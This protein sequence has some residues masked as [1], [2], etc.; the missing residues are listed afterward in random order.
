MRGLVV[1]QM[2]MGIHKQL[3]HDL[4]FILALH[5][6]YSNNISDTI[7]QSKLNHLFIYKHF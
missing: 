6:V 7:I 2:G 3:L 1:K 5:L 4:L